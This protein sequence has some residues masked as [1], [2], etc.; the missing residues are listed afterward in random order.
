MKADLGKSIAISISFDLAP[1]CSITDKDESERGVRGLA[2]RLEDRF[3]FVRYSGV[4]EIQKHE[5]IV[6]DSKSTTKLRSFLSRHRHVVLLG[7]PVRMASIRR[8][9]YCAR[10][11]AM[12]PSRAIAAS[13]LGKHHRFSARS[14]R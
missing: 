1:A 12:S 6:V 10:R 9:P 2:E 5:I 4:A 3:E 8:M 7:F 13:S 14:I 11:F